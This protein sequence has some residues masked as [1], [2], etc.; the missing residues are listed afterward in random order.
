MKSILLPLDGSPLAEQALPYATSLAQRA[1]ARLMLVRATQAQSLLDVDTSDAEGGV[2]SR[3][4]HELEATAARLRDIGHDVDGYVY[5]ERPVLAILDAA[6]RHQVDLIVM[7]THGRS[8]LG[9]M[10]YGSV[11][12]DVLRHATVPVLLV[13]ALIDHAWPTDRPLTVLVPLDGSELAETAIESAGL[14]AERLGAR[15]HLLQV[16]QPPAY[17]LYGDGYVYVPFDDEAER[18]SARQYLETLA[19][20]LASQGQQAT[21]EVATGQPGTVIARV[22]GEQQAD[23]IAMATHGRGGLARLVLGSIATAT[24]QRAHV[25]LLMTRPA[26][27]GQPVP[28]P[29]AEEVPDPRAIGTR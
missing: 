11:A 14:L 29:P 3:A 27:L 12:D 13:P 20:K 23:V 17:P 8:G 28:L 19:E 26:E 21:F 15:L 24:L 1:G 22:A 7:S 5:Y 25:P 18:D 2:V 6:Q 4:E 16:V 10:V 9:R